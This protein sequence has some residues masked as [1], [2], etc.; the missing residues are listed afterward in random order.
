MVDYSIYWWYPPISSWE[1]GIYIGDIHFGPPIGTE[2]PQPNCDKIPHQD[3]PSGQVW[4]L[5]EGICQCYDAFINIPS[6][7]TKPII[8]N[9]NEPDIFKVL[10]ILD[11]YG[12]R[13]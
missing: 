8:S 9:G 3:C 13:K 6:E 12:R 7:R 4:G 10:R 11:E 1:V 5:Y 2:L